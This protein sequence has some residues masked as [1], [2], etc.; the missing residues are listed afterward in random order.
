MSSSCAMSCSTPLPAT[1]SGG[2]ARPRSQCAGCCERA[3]VTTA[4]APS[5]SARI[6]T[7]GRKRTRHLRVDE[8]VLHLPRSGARADAIARDAGIGS[9]AAAAHE[10]DTPHAS[11]REDAVPRGRHRRFRDAGTAIVSER[12]AVVQT[13]HVDVAGT[14]RAA[15]SVRIDVDVSCALGS[16][17]E[18]RHARADRRARRSPAAA[19]RRPRRR[20][21]RRRTAACV[22]DGRQRSRR[23]R[24]SSSRARSAVRA[25]TC[26]NAGTSLLHLRQ[27]DVPHPVALEAHVVVGRVLA[28]RD[29]VRD[30]PRAQ[31]A[32]RT[33][34][35]GRTKI[36][37]T[38]AIASSES[39]AHE[40]Q[41]DGLGL[42]VGRVR[43]Q[44]RTRRP[45]SRPCVRARRTAHRAPRLRPRGPSR[46]RRRDVRTARPRAAA[47]S[48]TNSASATSR[49]ASVVDVQKRARSGRPASEV[50]RARSNR[51]RRCTRHRC[52]SSGIDAERS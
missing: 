38:G 51:R 47:V 30:E 5:S 50:Q 18:R 22:D 26:V 32:R 39:A 20:C 37:R 28:P 42:V 12:E 17:S 27:Q 25:S 3:P 49:R 46:R 4:S 21:R 14:R 24:A 34:S 19:V 31:L 36:P 29:A 43:G 52:G 48:R 2:T 10:I 11:R 9:R 15:V 33:S 23:A 1:T 6:G 13:P 35:S 7:S 8:D 41:Q 45:R 16:R 44:R 40:P